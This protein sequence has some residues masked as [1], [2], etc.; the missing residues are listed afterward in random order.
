MIVS[1]L[2]PGGRSASLTLGLYRKSTDTTLIWIKC[3]CRY[4]AQNEATRIQ[5]K[6]PAA[7]LEFSSP[8]RAGKR[9]GVS[10]EVLE[11]GRGNLIL[12]V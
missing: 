9:R 5:A 10:L 6:A 12:P 4:A 7:L 3:T 8:C 1:V 11:R 2:D